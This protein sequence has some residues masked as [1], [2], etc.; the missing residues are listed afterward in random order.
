[1][2]TWIWISWTFLY[3]HFWQLGCTQCTFCTA[4]RALCTVFPTFLSF[5]LESFNL[6]CRREFGFHECS[7]TAIFDNWGAH[8]AHFTTAQHGLCT[9]FPNFCFSSAL[10]WCTGVNLDFANIL[11]HYFLANRVYS[12]TAQCI[13][14]D[15]R[16]FGSSYILVSPKKWATHLFT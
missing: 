13:L 8:N 11:I 1:M 5:K 16:V 15:T 3:C 6:V 4:Q 7:Y 14:L 2:Q 10:I 12:H 9:V